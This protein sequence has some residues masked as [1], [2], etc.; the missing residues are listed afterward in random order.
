MSRKMC[1]MWYGVTERIMT[2]SAWESDKEVMNVFIE[3]VTLDL[4]IKNV[5]GF[6]KQKNKDT[7]NSTTNI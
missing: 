4:G 7:L 3:G 5:S 1:V 2:Y 6:F